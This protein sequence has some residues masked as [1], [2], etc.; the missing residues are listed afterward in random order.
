MN[1]NNIK[2][3]LFTESGILLVDKPPTW[4][5]H[6]VVNLIRR[7]FN[8]G[9]VGHCGT[10]DPAAT[11]L[12]VLVLGKATALSQHL[13][14]EDKIYE[15]TMLLG[16]ETDS[17][18]MDGKITRQKSWENVK[19]ENI[20]KICNSFIGEQFQIPPMVSAKKYQ[21]KRLYKLAREGKE[22]ERKP[23]K[24]NIYSFSVNE[25]NLPYIKFT[26]HC[27]KGTYIRVLCYD[28][29]LKL[30]CGAVLFN[31]RRN[32]SGKFT[33]EKA[34]SIEQIKTWTQKDL[35]KHLFFGF[36]A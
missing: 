17:M 4:T 22:V 31:L 21:G 3:P 28:I 29:G 2:L 25:I 9:K 27:S 13:S 11:G 26:V 12:L 19:P 34:F 15:A 16:T 8:V 36:L 32:Q 18:D 20:K 24:I 1:N 5:S 35:S 10:L 14:G 23:Q 30:G 6:D 33:I 7:R